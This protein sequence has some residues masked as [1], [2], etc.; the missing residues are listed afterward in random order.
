M[1][2]RA[3][4]SDIIEVNDETPLSALVTESSDSPD[5]IIR[6]IN[7]ID[8]QRQLLNLRDREYRCSKCGNLMVDGVVTQCCSTEMC[9]KCAYFCQF[10]IQVNYQ[11]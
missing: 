11:P 3:F 10:F 6:V 4:E 7:S 9:A 5:A 2:N 8:L 1:E